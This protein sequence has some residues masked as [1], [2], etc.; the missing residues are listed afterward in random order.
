MTRP[1]P[2]SIFC[3]LFSSTNLSLESCKIDNDIVPERKVT[4]FLLSPPFVK[5]D[6]GGFN[7]ISIYYKIPPSPPL[8]K[9]G[10]IDGF[11]F[12]YYIGITFLC[13]HNTLEFSK[14]KFHKIHEFGMIFV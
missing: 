12:K 5:G 9:G 1:S 4:E 3:R 2:T 8:S 6:L 10:R 13:F 7:G 11:S 14:N